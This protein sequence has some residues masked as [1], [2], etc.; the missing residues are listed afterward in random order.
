M[1]FIKW[2]WII[3][4]NILTL[5]DSFLKIGTVCILAVIKYLIDRK[6]IKSD[7]SSCVFCT[8]WDECVINQAISFIN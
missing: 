3:I 2:R 8:V 4:K 5:V 1:L 6:S 7:S